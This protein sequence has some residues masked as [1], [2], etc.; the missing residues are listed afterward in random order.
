MIH[1]DNVSDCITIK[2]G[3]QKPDQ[4]DDWQDEGQ[5]DEG[6][7]RQ[8]HWRA[9]R[10]HG[11]YRRLGHYYRASVGYDLREPISPNLCGDG[12]SLDWW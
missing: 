6:S 4:K 8:N 2:A 11:G 3:Y 12:V 5:K 9:S 10:P 7:V 1:N